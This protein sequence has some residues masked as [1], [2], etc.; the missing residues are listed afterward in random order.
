MDFANFMRIERQEGGR[1]RHY[2]V[3]LRDPKFTMEIEPDEAAPDQVGKGVIKRLRLPNSWAGNYG[4][5]AKWLT[6]AQEFFQRSFAAPDESGAA[7]V[8][9]VPPQRGS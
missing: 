2:V 5:Y 4:Q 3:H 9:S 1:T 6:A 7:R 8:G